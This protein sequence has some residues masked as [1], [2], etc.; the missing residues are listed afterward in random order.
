VFEPYNLLAAF[1]FGCVGLGAFSYGKKLRLWQPMVIGLC[2]MGYPWFVTNVW[3]TWAVG[4]V[5]CVLL[6]FFHDQ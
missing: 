2:L 4:V 1:I 5:F 3:L 6:Y